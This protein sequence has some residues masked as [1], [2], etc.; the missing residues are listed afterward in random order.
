MY[1]NTN[2]KIM[3]KNSVAALILRL[4]FGIYMIFGHGLS[5]FI[6]FVNGNFQFAELFGLPASVNL[7]LAVITE[8]I[9][10]IF[11]VLGY[12]TRYASIPVIFT[13]AVAAFVA[14]NG[15]PWFAY[16]AK[17]GGSKEMAMLF[18]FGFAAIAFLGSGK[19]SL[20]AV[21]GRKYK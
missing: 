11:V 9:L 17:G 2:S 20:D 1:I 5:K 7:G 8:F 18:L 10:P 3:D 19:Y 15:D 13:M 21:L 14:H 16:Q 6:K 4:G 12:F